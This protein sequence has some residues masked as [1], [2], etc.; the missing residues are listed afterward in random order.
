MLTAFR[1]LV[2][3]DFTEANPPSFNSIDNKLSYYT[4]LLKAFSELLK[5]QN[6]IYISIWL[7]LSFF[8]FLLFCMKKKK[9]RTS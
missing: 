7:F 8:F 4:V 3:W 6:V 9:N 1:D 2:R 5:Y